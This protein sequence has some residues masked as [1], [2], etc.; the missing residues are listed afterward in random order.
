MSQELSEELI[1]LQTQVAFQEQAI[2]ELGDVLTLQQ[3]QIDLLRTEV[4]RLRE[5]CEEGRDGNENSQEDERP[6]HY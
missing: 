5:S 3:Q 2:T 1:E 6:P 4:Q